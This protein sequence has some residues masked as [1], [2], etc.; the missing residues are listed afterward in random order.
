MTSVTA[1]ERRILV[2]AG[3]GAGLAFGTPIAGIFLALKKVGYVNG[4]EES[5]KKES[6]PKGEDAEN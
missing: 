1:A 2:A 4:S 6:Y 3:A 5:I